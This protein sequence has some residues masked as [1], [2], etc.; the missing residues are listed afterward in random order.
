VVYLL[1][2]APCDAAPCTSLVRT[3]D[4]GRS[5]RGVPAPRVAIATAAGAPAA[6]PDAVSQVRFADPRDGWAFGGGLWSTHDAAAS[7]ASW[8]KVDVGGAVLDLA[9]DGRTVW[10]LVADCGTDGTCSGARLL[11]SPV[12]RDEFH[13]ADRVYV[14]GRITG[15]RLQLAGGA[16]T[17]TVDGDR[18][19][20]FVL[21]GDRW[22]QTAR[23][24]PQG[25]AVV[26]TAAAP[27][28]LVAL[29]PTDPGAGSV[30]YTTSRST[31]LGRTWTAAAGA[32]RVPNGQAEEFAAA[33]AQDLAAAVGSPDLGGGLWVSQDGG[34]S[35]AP[36]PGLPRLTTGWAWVGAAGGG[37]YLAVPFDPTGALWESRDGGRTWRALAP[38]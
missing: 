33:S 12:G 9:T 4:G 34:R 18:P 17:L 14:K 21:D 1:G 10:A 7:T 22:R 30:T 32:L 8:R 29:C 28:A 2:D 13:D 25:G 26:P 6:R 31:D 36:G 38:R 35:W 37:R 23:P 19:A 27:A 5:W 16:G 24:C 20:L 11:R 3:A 15:A